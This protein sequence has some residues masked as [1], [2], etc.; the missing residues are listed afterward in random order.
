[1]GLLVNDYFKSER[2]RVGE[3]PWHPLASS[4]ILHK[5]MF[6]VVVTE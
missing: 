1:M 6:T 2:G 5:L 4:V 3:N